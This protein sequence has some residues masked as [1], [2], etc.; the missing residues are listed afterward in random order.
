MGRDRAMKDCRFDC[1]E[2]KADCP[3]RGCGELCEE[4]CDQGGE[5]N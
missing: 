4:K 2:C 1:Q 3:C 5:Q